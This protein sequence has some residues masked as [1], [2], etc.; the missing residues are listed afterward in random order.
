M[1][2]MIKIAEVK[3]L[4]LPS[5]R[6]FEEKVLIPLY[7]KWAET[8]LQ[9]LNEDLNYSIFVLSGKKFSGGSKILITKEEAEN[10]SYKIN[11][12]Q[13]LKE[14]SNEI[15]TKAGFPALQENSND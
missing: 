14:A 5:I 13:K 3:T 11:F 1:T 9:V 15:L 7:G 6:T 4:I 2:E 8:D 12:R 10:G